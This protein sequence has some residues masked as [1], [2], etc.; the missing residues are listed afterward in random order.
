ML[1]FDNTNTAGH[2]PLFVIVLLLHRDV[3]G[4]VTEGNMTTKIING[5]ARPNTTVADA[6]VVYKTFR[7]LPMNALLSFLNGFRD[8]KF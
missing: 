1:L 2:L 8:K 6:K 4:V 7:K 3:M 5:S